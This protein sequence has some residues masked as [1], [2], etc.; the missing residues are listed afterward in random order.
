MEH[1]SI[2]PFS[3]YSRFCS[4]NHPMIYQIQVLGQGEFLNISFEPQFIE[5]PILAGRYKQGK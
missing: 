3:R 1:S 2:A 4:L 5:S